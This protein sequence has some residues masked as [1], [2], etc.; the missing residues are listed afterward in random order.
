MKKFWIDFIIGWHSF[1]RLYILGMLVASFW[2]DELLKP[3]I[4]L[5]CIYVITTL[6]RKEV[7]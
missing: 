7:E 3:T 2:F 5:F 4:I 1:V 6:E